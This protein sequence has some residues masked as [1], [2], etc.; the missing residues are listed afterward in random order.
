MTVYNYDVVV[1]GSGPAGE[2]AAMNAAMITAANVNTD[3]FANLLADQLRPLAA[4]PPFSFMRRPLFSRRY[5]AGFPPCA[6]I[7]RREL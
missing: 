6:L 2:G 5:R 1:L 3:P 4:R 7:V